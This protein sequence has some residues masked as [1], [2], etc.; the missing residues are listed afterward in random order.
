[1]SLWLWEKRKLFRESQRVHLVTHQ[2]MHRSANPKWNF[3][4]WRTESFLF[5]HQTLLPT[6]QRQHS[7]P[8][9]AVCKNPS[10]A[11]QSAKPPWKFILSISVSLR[12]RRRAPRVTP[13]LKTLGIHWQ[14]NSIPPRSRHNASSLIG[15]G[16]Y[17]AAG[18]F[19]GLSWTFRIDFCRS[20][21]MR[22]WWR[23]TP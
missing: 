3:R 12:R 19:P 10:Y 23:A 15:S 16:S 4:K 2:V 11:R 7:K 14:A 17:S 21:T 5:F 9:S 18:F 20:R 8:P 6:S 1:M 22:V 13:P